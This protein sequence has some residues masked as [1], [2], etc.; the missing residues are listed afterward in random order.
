MKYIFQLN[1]FCMMKRLLVTCV[2]LLTTI[3]ISMSQTTNVRGVVTSS[4]D[5]LPLP[6]VNVLV[7]GT[8]SGTVTDLDGNFSIQVAQ[9]QTLVFSFVGYDTQEI[10]VG[11]QTNLNVLLMIDARTMNEV[12]VVGYG[13]QSRRDLT[14]SVGSVKGEDIN[15][16]PVASVDNALQGRAAGVF[17]QSPSGTPGAGITMQIRG[18][19]SLSASSQ[20][21]YVIDGIPMISEDLSGLFSGGQ[22]TNSLADINPADIESIEILKDAS[23]A[24]IYGSRGANGVVLITTKRGKSGDAKIDINGFY[25]FQ[26]IT[27]EID[28]H[29]SSEFLSLMNDAIRQDLRAGVQLPYDN[30]TDV[31]GFSPDDPDLQNTRWF[32]EIF[33]DAPIQSYDVAISGG[34]EKT[35]YYTSLAYFNQDGVQIGTGFERVSA[36]LNVD[37]QA[38]KWLKVGT[39][40]NLSRTVQD[41]TINDNSLYGVVIN[42]LAGDPLMPVREADGSYADPFDYFGWWMLDNPVLIAENYHRF[43]R[44]VR[45]LA[46]TYAEATLAPGLTLRSTLGIDY[47][48]LEDESYTPIISRESVNGNFNGFGTFGSTQDFTWIAE[49]YLNYTKS[50]GADNRHNI[51]ALLGTSYQASS[52]TFSSISA[53]NFPSDQFTKLSVAGRVTAASTSGTDWGLASYFFRGNYNYADKFLA[54]FTVRADGSS[55]FGDNFRFGIF[56]SGSVAYRLSEEEFLRNTA[57]SDLKFRASYGV[58]GNQDGIGNFASRGLFGVSAYRL[59]PT[60]TPAQ[61]SNANLT[62]ESTEQWN[63]GVDFG[64]LNDRITFTGDYFVKTTTDLLLNRP[65]PGISG[66]SSVIDNIGK[67]ENRGLELGIRGAILA[68]G[69]FTWSS[70]FNISWI[71]NKVLELVIDEQVLSDSHILAV[72]HPIGTFFLIDQEGVDPETGN[73][74]WVDLNG[75]GVINSGDRR[76]VGNSQPDFF[77]GWDNNFRYKGFDLNVLFNFIVGNQ[78]FNHSRATYENLGWSR[79]GLGFPLP[80]GNNHRLADNRWMEPGDVTDIPRASLTNVNWREYSSRWLEDGS[81][82]RLRMINL[83]YNF[84]PQRVERIGV[85]SL[86]VFVQAQNLLTWTRYTGL[87]PEVSQNA[88]DPRLA[89]SDFGTFPQTRSVSLGFNIGL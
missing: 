82:L 47:T 33:R 71:R 75:D 13:T 69:P 61:L 22:A 50:F 32:R 14:G 26:R 67:V 76:I 30:I 18:N 62:W 36:R 68:S 52:R 28:M 42:T 55:R 70:A 34:N 86:R 21:L 1:S 4:E 40:M 35:Q 15:R 58:V 79:L 59:A 16:M 29:S 85:R 54:T 83:G 48:Y 49:N 12:V 51:S 37:T 46:N 2:M 19:T 27:N 5:N 77:G 3:S 63:V 20:P 38:K 10:L 24:A 65:I 45:G 25:G 43:T 78:I 31:W 11:N 72:G 7:K 6:G 89:G 73:M 8:T 74:R 88:R 17:V 57:V 81:F 87:D 41:R 23:A 84:T 53:Q 64:V 56:P 60:L 39:S 80:D 66:F 9:G 44:T